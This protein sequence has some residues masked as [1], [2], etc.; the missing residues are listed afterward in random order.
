MNRDYYSQSYHYQE[1]G[2]TSRKFG[3]WDSSF[4]GHESYARTGVAMTKIIETKKS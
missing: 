4:V 3:L 1:G 2:I